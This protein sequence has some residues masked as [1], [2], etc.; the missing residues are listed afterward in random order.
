M[1]LDV[2]DDGVGFDPDAICPAPDRGFGLRAIRQRIE[3]LARRHRHGDKVEPLVL[4][5]WV[6]RLGAA[7]V[8]LRD[9][10]KTM[11]VSHRTDI[12]KDL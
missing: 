5:N 4:S 9:N 11:V 7:E 10:I 1:S 3:A 6:T 12:P 2:A 8:W